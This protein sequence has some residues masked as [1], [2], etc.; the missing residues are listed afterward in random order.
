[1]PRRARLASLATTI[2]LVAGCSSSSGNDAAPAPTPGVCSLAVPMLADTHLT[3]SGTTLRDALG[4]HVILRGVNAGGRSKFAPYVPFD[5][6]GDAFQAAADAY[7]DRAASW[8]IDMVR[9]PFTWAAVEP[10]KGTDDAAFL[11][12]YDAL[13]DAAWKRRIYVLVDFHQDVFAQEYCGDGF[14]SW[15]LP[16]P[17]P[18]PH[19]DCPA[20]FFAYAQDDKVR[21][22]FDRF[23]VDQDGVK[24]AY[25]ALWDRM[26]ARY[27]ARPGVVG[28][29]V[30][31]EPN[32]GTA[33]D[34][35]AWETTTLTAFYGEV[36][37][38]VHAAAPGVLVYFEPTPE[39]LSAPVTALGRPAG[40]RLVFA[41]HWY[42]FTALGGKKAPPADQ[43]LPALKPLADQAAA[44]GVPVHLGE[45]GVSHDEEGAGDY[46]TAHYDVLDQ[47]QMSSTQW[48]YSVAKETWNAETLGLVDA[49]GTE[50]SELT[51]A[52][53]RAY[54][55]AIAGN[56]ATWK[57]D[58]AS[59]TLTLSYTP[60]A[61][62]ITE[63][64]APQRVYA[65]PPK[66]TVKGGCGDGVSAA[67]LV[68][69]KDDGTGAKV[70][71]TVSP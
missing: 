71:V 11:A 43:V 4:R 41:P 18:A 32:A 20:W 34:P 66:V 35:A 12:R 29:D 31:N 47:L 70:E 49:D 5:F 39:G 64:V 67:G 27:A 42:A 63:I 38:R 60:I 57:Y 53:T 56:D 3:T 24:T 30:F 55:R 16:Q 19:H 26:A 52:I 9:L 40:D 7:F 2:A 13:I 8:G 45:C 62:G 37:A 6:V 1:M 46:L 25:L 28:F 50:R 69:V 65:S 36:S 61:G 22:A 10:T 17:A 14:P 44:L 58:A 68:L 21:S 33:K 48:E 51:G 23:W 54:P 15:A 59:K